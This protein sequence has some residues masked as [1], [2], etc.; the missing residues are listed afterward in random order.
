MQSYCNILCNN[1]IAYA[2]YLQSDNYEYIFLNALL[3][4]TIQYT[5]SKCQL[6]CYAH[7]LPHS[8]HI[9]Y[10]LLHIR[11]HYCNCLNQAANCHITCTIK[12]IYTLKKNY[13]P[14]MCLC[15]ILL[16]Q[17]NM[18][19]QDVHCRNKTWKKCQL[20]CYSICNVSD[21]NWINFLPQIMQIVTL[22]RNPTSSYH[23]TQNNAQI[24]LTTL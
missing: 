3:P 6:L 14:Y 19:K 8:L 21:F 12:Q 4:T 22:G 18:N 5:L 24:N 2:K 7:Y 11:Q 23:S 20:Y 9:H 16:T 15:H 1:T 10:M 17:K 13:S